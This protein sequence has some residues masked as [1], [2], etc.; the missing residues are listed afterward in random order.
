MKKSLYATCLLFVL[1]A[2]SL[3]LRAQVMP[4][5]PAFKVGVGF[6]YSRG[7]YGFTRDTEVW[8]TPAII[9]YESRDWLIRATIPYVTIS[10]PASV[11][12]DTGPAIAGPARPSSKSQS[13][14]GDVVLGATLHTNPSSTDVKFDLTGRVKLPTA[15]DSKG[16]GTGKADFYTQADIY[17][18]IDR[19]TPFGSIGYRFLGDSATYRVKDGLY[20]SAGLIVRAVAGTAFGASYDWRSR[21]VDGGD[22]STDVSVFVTHNLNDRWNVVLYA[23]KGFDSGSPDYGLGG[24]ILYKF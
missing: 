5:P 12:G 18:P 15:D 21:L 7:S 14:L 2:P 1:V 3:K 11:V 20:A 22:D 4:V 10:G 23:L 16:L 19:L 24:Q 13:G 9:Q 6:D 8:S 17:V